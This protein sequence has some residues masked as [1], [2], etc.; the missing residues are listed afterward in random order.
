MTGD[1]RWRLHSLKPPPRS[2]PSLWHPAEEIAKTGSGTCSDGDGS[3]LGISPSGP[4][5]GASRSGG[6]V[7]L[8]HAAIFTWREGEM[9]GFPTK[10]VGTQTPRNRA[11]TRRGR[12][13][14]A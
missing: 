8:R 7:P 5:V 1:G 3:P 10:S 4:A 12:S 9:A 6:I 2:L 14:G 11:A 13:E